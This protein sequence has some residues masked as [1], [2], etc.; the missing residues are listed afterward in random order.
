MNKNGGLLGNGEPVGN[1]GGKERAQGNEYKYIVCI[2]EE[3]NNETHF[4]K[5]QERLKGGGRK[6]DK[7]NRVGEYDQSILY[8]FMEMSQGN[9]SL[10]N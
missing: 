1:G 6:E 8:A 9:S 7:S 2:Y 4:K 10:C 5:L 3:V